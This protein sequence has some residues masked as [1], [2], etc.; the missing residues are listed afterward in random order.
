MPKLLIYLG[1]LGAIV[2]GSIVG[3]AWYAGGP[4]PENK[5]KIEDV[6]SPKPQPQPQPQPTPEEVKPIPAQ[7]PK[8]ETKPSKPKPPVKDK[9]DCFASWLPGCSDTDL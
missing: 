5:T 4:D 2:I 3:L 1:L 6:I 9:K 7:P 8:V